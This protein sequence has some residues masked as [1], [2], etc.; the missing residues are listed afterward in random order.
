MI[1]DI[2]SFL[3]DKT[4]S[5]EW[6]FS[7]K[8]EEVD[9][10]KPFVSPVH[11]NCTIH[12]HESLIDLE[13]KISYDFLMPCSLCMKETLKHEKLTL[14]HGLVLKECE[15]SD[16]YNI[17]VDN[18]L[19]LSSLI[20]EE[21]LL[22]LPYRHICSDDCKGLCPQCGT[23]LNETKCSC[24]GGTIDERLKILSDLLS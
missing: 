8:E 12:S 6:D 21:I 1:I 7:M 22:T 10:F 18:S 13:A 2:R 19:D 11:V 23:N 5:F 17:K 20:T 24:N 16:D 3:V 4:E 15:D 14:K 9:G